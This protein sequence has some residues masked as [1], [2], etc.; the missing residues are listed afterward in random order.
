MSPV[1]EV[2]KVWN[3]LQRNTGIV[4]I[5]LHHFIE[6]ELLQVEYLPHRASMLNSCAWPC[7]SEE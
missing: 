3:E 7:I 2:S 6:V 4:D 1:V 5:P